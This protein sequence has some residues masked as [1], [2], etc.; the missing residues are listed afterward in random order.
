MLS[1]IAD[2]L[3]LSAACAADAKVNEWL[4]PLLWDSCSKIVVPIT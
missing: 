3:V 4:G 2:L 1:L